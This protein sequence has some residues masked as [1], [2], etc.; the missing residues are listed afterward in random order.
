MV[1]KNRDLASATD[2]L[3]NYTKALTS[4]SR[5]ISVL[6][7]HVLPTKGFENKKDKYKAYSTLFGGCLYMAVSKNLY[8][9][10]RSSQ[11]QLLF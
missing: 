5:A 11:P 1:Q 7:V 3:S 4:A 8:N 6:S 2:G 9:L 10:F